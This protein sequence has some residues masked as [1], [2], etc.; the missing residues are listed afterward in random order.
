MFPFC[1]YTT[2]IIFSALYDRNGSNVTQKHIHINISPYLSLN[3]QDFSCLSNSTVF[4]EHN[5][6]LDT[7]KE[8]TINNDNVTIHL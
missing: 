7:L 8:N 4:I 3:F 5:T 6:E 1:L 2:F